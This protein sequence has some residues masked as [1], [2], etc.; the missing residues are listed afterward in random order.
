MKNKY[1][2]NYKK[3]QLY[4]LYNTGAP[5]RVMGDYFETSVTAINK[6]L[7][8]FNIRESGKSKIML[9]EDIMVMSVDGAKSVISS[10]RLDYDSVENQYAKAGMLVDVLG[11]H[12]SEEI[13]QIMKR[14]GLNFNGVWE[15]PKRR[16][17][18]PLGEN[19]SN[20][21]IMLA[22]SDSKIAK[23]R[24]SLLM[25]F[26]KEETRGKDVVINAPFSRVINY[27]REKGKKIEFINRKMFKVDDERLTDSQVL[28]MANK[29]RISL[30]LPIF[31]VDQITEY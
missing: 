2:N 1:W 26:L 28:V 12:P 15:A 4:V 14:Y 24:G 30:G 9:C 5:L 27:L 29:K 11:F 7:S 6:A 8:R 16:C 23:F 17:A 19:Y 10:F 18:K 21:D 22:R 31:N 20:R 13:K 3:Y 25:K